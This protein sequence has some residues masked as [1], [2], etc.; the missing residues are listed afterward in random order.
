MVRVD[1]ID[2]VSLL[3]VEPFE[4]LGACKA[5]LAAGVC[6]CCGGGAGAFRP[7]CVPMYRVVCLAGG[8]SHCE[9]WLGW[10][11]LLGPLPGVGAPGLVW[12]GALGHV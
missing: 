4:E 10:G 5:A 6:Q 9:S 3:Q 8:Y 7:Q 12:E 11:L 1:G 2:Q